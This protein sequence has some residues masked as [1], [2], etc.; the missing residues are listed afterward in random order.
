[1]VI[2]VAF[3]KSKPFRHLPKQFPWFDTATKPGR[4]LHK[5]VISKWTRLHRV[6]NREVYTR[7]FGNSRFIMLVNI[8]KLDKFKLAVYNQKLRPLGVEMVHVKQTDAVPVFN[9]M[10]LNGLANALRSSSATPTMIVYAYGN[11]LSPLGNVESIPIIKKIIKEFHKNKRKPNNYILAGAIDRELLTQ[12]QLLSI[13][14]Y[15]DPIDYW[16]SLN[17]QL[18]VAAQIPSML[19]L[20]QMSLVN[21]LQFYSDQDSDAS[22]K[23]NADE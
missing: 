12:R 17:G 19:Q 4:G 1:M 2:K 5:K 9:N 20:S 18:S 23:S 7:W 8:E 15:Q 21:A 16:S 13:L 22:S 14:D 11:E 3:E 6:F 10:R